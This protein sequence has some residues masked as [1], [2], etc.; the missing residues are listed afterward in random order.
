MN[1]YLNVGASEFISK[2]ITLN[3]RAKLSGSFRTSQMRATVEVLVVKEEE[4]EKLNTGL[5]PASLA[6]TNYVPGGKINVVLD[7][8]TYFLII[9]N[10]KN[11]QP[12][13]VFTDINLE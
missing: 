13:S 8:G 5:D 3:R 9:D 4:F 12:R 7:P 6:K 1:G 11:D 2:K 10:R